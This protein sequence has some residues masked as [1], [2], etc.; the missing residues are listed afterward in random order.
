MDNEPGEV[1]ACARPFLPSPE[2]VEDGPLSFAQGRDLQED[3]AFHDIVTQLLVSQHLKR[4]DRLGSSELVQ[5]RKSFPET[6]G[7]YMFQ[8]TQ[9]EVRD[10]EADMRDLQVETREGDGHCQVCCDE[11]EEVGNG[12][13][14]VKNGLHLET[15]LQLGDEEFDEVNR[16][17]GTNNGKRR[18]GC[19]VVGSRFDVKR[20]RN[21]VSDV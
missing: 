10:L 7:K 17:C 2:A 21:D 15:K 6:Y 13:M 16:E 20:R 18:P 5:L 19:G 8:E 9:G 14:D 12:I 3:V 1:L 11:I 4:V